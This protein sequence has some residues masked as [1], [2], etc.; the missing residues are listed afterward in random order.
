MNPIRHQQFL[1]FFDEIDAALILFPSGIKIFEPKNII[2]SVEKK[3]GFG[4]FGYH[5]NKIL[6]FTLNQ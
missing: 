3:I 5:R 4:S 6:V 1:K 2:N